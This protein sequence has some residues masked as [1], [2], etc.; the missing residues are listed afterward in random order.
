MGG[1]RRWADDVVA[2]RW[3]RALRSECLRNSEYETPAQLG[4]TIGAF[5]ER[6]NDGR[7]HQALGHQTPA[8]WH[9]S[10][11]AEAA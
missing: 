2:E 4:T 3:F 11:V 1:R 5:V 7:E 10:G 8:E 6:Y 9:C